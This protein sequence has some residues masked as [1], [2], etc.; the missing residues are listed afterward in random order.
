MSKEVEKT[1]WLVV[2]FLKDF[3]SYKKGDTAKYHTSTADKLIKNKI[4][5]VNEELKK[6]APK[7]EE[8]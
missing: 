3:G 6:Y 8:K 5:K 4:V 2:E 1:G 7:K